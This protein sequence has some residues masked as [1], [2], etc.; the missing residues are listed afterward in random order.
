[1]IKAKGERKKASMFF[2]LLSMQAYFGLDDGLFRW[3]KD[4][5]ANKYVLWLSLQ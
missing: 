3:W 1:M 5:N 4:E 2:F